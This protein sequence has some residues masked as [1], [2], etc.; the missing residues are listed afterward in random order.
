MNIIC[1]APAP[2]QLICDHNGKSGVSALNLLEH[3]V[4]RQYGSATRD[5]YDLI[6]RNQKYS[7]I[8]NPKK[9]STNENTKSN[10]PVDSR[11]VY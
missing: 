10:K 5:A 6:R 9:T 1:S 11:D 7:G 3:W 2:V 8:E 4:N